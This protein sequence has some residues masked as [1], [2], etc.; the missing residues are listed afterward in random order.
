MRLPA[1]VAAPPAGACILLVCFVRIGC[2]G[3]CVQRIFLFFCLFLI[4]NSHGEALALHAFSADG[5]PLY[6]SDFTHFSYVNPHAPKGGELRCHTIGTFDSFNPLLLKGRPAE[7]IHLIYDTL[8]VESE[9]ERDVAYGLLASEIHVPPDLSHVIFQLHPEARFADGSPV[10]G[11]DVVFSWE[12]LQAHFGS[13]LRRY[14]EAVASVTV[15]SGNRVRF[16]F[17]EQ[18]NPS[19]VL[20]VGRLQILPA[21]YWEDKDFGRADLTPP[22]GS[23]PYAVAEV[24]AGRRVVYARRVDYWAADHPVNRGRWNFDRIRYEYFRDDTV[25]MEAFRA[26]LY[27]FRFES[28]VKNWAT[29]YEGPRFGD[30]RIL[31]KT[32]ENRDPSGM[33]GLV[34]NTRRPVFADRRIRKAMLSA[35]DFEWANRRFYYGEY[36][37]TESYFENSDM[38]APPLADEGEA[39][40]LRSFGDDLPEGVLENPLSLPLTDG[41]G[42]NREGLMEADR[43]LREA[44]WV[45]EGGRRVHGKTKQVFRF[46]FL[47]DS[48]REE[49]MLLPFARSLGRLGIEMRIHM[50]DGPQYTRRLRDCDFDMIVAGFGAAYRPGRELAVAFHSAS[51]DRKDQR[52][53]M[54]I[55]DPVADGLIEKILSRESRR[56]MIPYVRALDRILRHGHYVIPFGAGKRRYLARAV[57]IQSPETP[58]PWGRGVSTWWYGEEDRAAAPASE[59]ES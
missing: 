44:G 34:M 33:Y 2:P 49:R 11:E 25:A 32:L 54:G 52:N 26:G 48:R 20:M 6:A 58:P 24:E 40:I 36:E 16:D 47:T 42:H 37:R 53:F 55:A 51:R 7:G 46:Q 13:A 19:L 43:L 3:M 4:M 18:Q 38:K 31:K 35:F 29:R 8:L 5:E 27:D 15:L 10:R 22:M 1:C 28:S 12:M 45:V 39:A 59:G 23:G 57:H 17:R 9:D 56:E 50:V 30:G 14:S 21:H 41:S